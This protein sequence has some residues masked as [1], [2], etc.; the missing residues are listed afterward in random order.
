MIWIWQGTVEAEQTLEMKLEEMAD[1]V[2]N[3]SD[4]A[5]ETN[6]KLTSCM[7]E[8]SAKL[9]SLTDKFHGN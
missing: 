6:E 8:I 3:L 4:M 7:N 9:D 1:R 5:K 2:C